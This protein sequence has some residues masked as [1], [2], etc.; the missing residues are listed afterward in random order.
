MLRGSCLRGGVRYDIADDLL[1]F[2]ELPK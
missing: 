1:Q 2:A